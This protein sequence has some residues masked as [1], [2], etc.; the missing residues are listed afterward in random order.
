MLCWG[1]VVSS[2]SLSSFVHTVDDCLE[3]TVKTTKGDTKTLAENSTLSDVI[4][5][6][7]YYSNGSG[8]DM[9][10]VMVVLVELAM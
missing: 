2:M 9:R 4:F 1:I 8:Q 7:V 10:C 6:E 3:G 5:H